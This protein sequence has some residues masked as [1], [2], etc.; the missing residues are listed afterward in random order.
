M[1][2]TRTRSRARCARSSAIRRTSSASRASSRSRATRRAAAG[3]RAVRRAG[4][5]AALRLPD[6]RLPPRRSSTTGSRGRGTTSCSARPA[7][8]RS[9]VAT[10]S[11]SSAAGRA[12]SPARTSSS[13]SGSTGCCAPAGRDYRIACLPDCVGVTEGPDTV[14]E[15]RLAARA[16]AARDPRD[17]LG[18]QADVVQPAVRDGRRCSACRTTSSRRSSRPSSRCSRSPRSLAG[19]ATGLVDWWEFAVLTLA[20]HVRE[21]RADDRR[22]ADARP[23]APDVPAVGRGAARSR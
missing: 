11:R 17:V 19:A 10:S 21:Q 2:F 9:G 8:S 1:V 12:S 20:D 13:H 6:V 15:A 3:R 14:A 5:A 16:L 23:R 18:E 7:R 22:P 4:H